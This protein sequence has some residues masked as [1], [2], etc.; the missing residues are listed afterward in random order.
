MEYRFEDIDR[1]PIDRHERVD[2]DTNATQTVR[3]ILLQQFQLKAQIEWDQTVV[4]T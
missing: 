2:C 3:E 4:R 1:K